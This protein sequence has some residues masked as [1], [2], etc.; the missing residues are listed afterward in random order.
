[1]SVW[2]DLAGYV[3]SLPPEGQASFSRHAGLDLTGG[4]EAAAG[5]LLAYA[6]KN[7]G[8]SPSSFLSSVC[9]QAAFVR[10]TELA[11]RTGEAALQLAE[12]D[13]ER[14][15][16]HVALAQLH[17]QNRREEG[18]LEAFVEHCLEAVRL[19]HAGTFCYERLATLYEYRGQTEEAREISRRAVEVL[20]AAGDVRSAER[21]RRRLERLSARQDRG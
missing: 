10:D 21:F 7:P 16:A 18:E 14:Q 17:F 1:L 12:T 8:V 20:E 6:E 13:E 11:R 9:S 3:A 2:D 5:V 19:G 4:R 15:L